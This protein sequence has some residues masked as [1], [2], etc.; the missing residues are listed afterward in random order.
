MDDLTTP[1]FAQ[2]LCFKFHD[3]RPYEIQLKYKMNQEFHTLNLQKRG[4]ASIPVIHLKFNGPNKINKK[5][6]DDIGTLIKFIP[7]IYHTYCNSLIP[8]NNTSEEEENLVI[9]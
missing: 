4:K 5:K 2:A 7:P 3:K 6:L 8:E 9:E 1:R